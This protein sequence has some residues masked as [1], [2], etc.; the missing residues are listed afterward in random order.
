MNKSYSTVSLW[1]LWKTTPLIYY[2]IEEDVRLNLSTMFAVDEKVSKTEIHTLLC[3]H[4][5][6][7][8]P[9]IPC[10]RF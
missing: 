3:N 4:D 10:N 6:A 5:E 9:A 7:A 8:T 1:M 2:R